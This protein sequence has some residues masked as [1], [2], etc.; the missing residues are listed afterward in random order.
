MPE[1]PRSERR[2]QNRVIAQFTD[3]ARPESLGYRYLGE[4]S[5]RENNRP[6]ETALLRENLTARGYSAAHI[7]AALQKLETAADATGITLYQANLRTYQLLRYPVKVQI[8]AGQPHDDVDLIDW[9]NAEKNDFGL[10]EEVTLK[11]GHQRRPDVV[12]YINGIAIAVIELKRSSVE[13]ADGVRQLITNQEEIFNKAFFSTVQL[14]LAG[15]DSQGLRYGT[16]GTPE[17]FFVEWKDGGPA[18]A[19]GSPPAG[20]LLD[21]PLAQLC[22]KT[23]LLDLIR[24]CVL[25]DGGQK[26]VPR[27]HQYFGLKAA[28]TRIAKR[29]GGVIWHTQGSGKSILMVLI[30]KWLLEHDPEARILVVTDRDEL[31]K[32]IEGVMKNAGVIGADSP[33]LRI[34]SR[35]E[36]VQKLGAAT[37]RLLCAL[38]HKFDPADLKGPPPAVQG[39][40][41]LFVDECHRTQGGDM[42]KQMKRWL[43]GAI[44]VGF[45]G[46][47]LLRKD[48]VTTR[49]VFGTYIHTY[50]FHEGVADGVIL[51]LKYEARDVP[52]RLT[53]QRAIDQWFEQKTRG[54]NNFQKAVLR[55]RWATMEE[56]M[57]AGERKQR[58]IASIIEDFSLKPRLN[59]DR[60]T[61]ILVAASIYDACHY[62]RFFQNT[63]FG[64]YCGIVTSYEPNHNLI[65]REPVNSD[66]R[67]KFDTYTQHVLRTYGQTTKQYEDEAK[68]RFIEEPANLKLLIV[69]SKLLTGF[70][71]PSCTYI[72]LDNELRDHN[73]FQAICRTNRLDGD[74]KDYGYIVDFKELFGDVQEALA[75]YNSDEL[76]TDAG[77]GGDNNVHLKDWLA[78]GRKQLDQAREA[79]RYLCEPVPLPREVEQFLHYFCG[80]SAN[81]NAL[82]E[83]EALRVTFYKATATFVRAFAAIAQDLTT[84]GYSDADAVAIQREVESY[85]DLRAA[86]KRHSGEELDIKPYEADMRHLINTYIQADPADGLGELGNMSLTELI[87][88]TGIHDAIARKLNEKGKLSRNAIAEGIINNVRKTIIRDQLTDPRF[89][90]QMSKLLDDLIQQSRIDTAAY[91]EFLCKAEA[92]VKR[93]AEKQP[94]A[95]VPSVLHGKREAI[96][97]YNNL[98]RILAAGRNRASRMAESSPDYGEERD[99]HVA[100]ALEIDRTI[101]ERAPAGWKGDQAREAQVLNALF[102]LL[103]RDREVTLALFELIKNQP[104]Y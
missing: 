46:T 28:Q 44:F 58:I 83:T 74:D 76:D 87:I 78:E 101:R 15:S 7:A 12:L 70:D 33:S 29:E 53:S 102:P 39:R 99:E 81:P 32:Q 5:K 62:Y 52:Q 14:V 51:D 21:R 71:A 89:Y 59:N 6:I 90:D 80:D 19:G 66:E 79:L 86:I 49:D 65:S 31:D 3:R 37:P 72:Y 77:N 69:V 60:G 84:A 57:S 26:K 27:P 93:L 95:G 75:V 38:V 24:N 34:T 4:W 1:Q 88:D 67:Y 20:A 64:Q 23:R 25:F 48:K 22:N 43:E 68:R 18:E 61:A 9:E 13:L 92:L 47:P 45:T 55:R 40:F 103:N 2:T 96:A 42:N 8:A 91:E 35:A 30:A 10:A 36:F 85:S 100:L 97:I 16:A 104:G 41:Y 54:L 82:N 17:Q 11:G 98:P 50:K 56:L 63:T 73:L 94:E